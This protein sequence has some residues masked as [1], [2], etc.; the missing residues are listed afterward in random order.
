[1]TSD[2]D[3]AVGFLSY[4]HLDDEADG[5]RIRR[6]AQKIQAEYRVL[7]G[8]Q[9][10]IF[11]DRS[12]LR[13]GQ[14]WR[15]RIDG[16]LQSTTFFIPVLSPSFFASDE[17]RKEF[18]N[19]FNTTRSLGVPRY[20]LAIRYAP[21]DDLVEGSADQAKAIAAETQYKSWDTLRLEDENS[22]VHRAA[23][24]DLATELRTLM[25]EVQAQPAQAATAK[26]ASRE[27]VPD[28]SPE[29]GQSA[30]NSSSS[31]LDEE[32][33]YGDA[34]SPVDLVAELPER[35]SAWT[36]TMNEF[37]DAN[38][39]FNSRLTA[40]SADL[41]VANQGKNAFAAKIVILRRVADELERP[42]MVLEDI[43]ERYMRALLE[44]DPSFRAFA[45]IARNQVN[46]TDEDRRSL[47]EA[48]KSVRSMVSAGREAAASVRGAI[49]S[50]RGLARISRDLRPVLRR[51]ETAS[52][53]V[54]DGQAVLEEWT[55]LMDDVNWPEEPDEP[56]AR[57]S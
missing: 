4:S 19:F 26:G 44:L 56:A 52:Q 15:E 8:D 1:M 5:G 35:A 31:S 41:D 36:E 6:L 25:R 46:P 30:S 14:K 40:G 20:L 39:E 42:S 54:I 28:E 45:E 50:G 51:Y 57:Q 34:P 12:D 7:T 37:R 24:N 47:N 27:E 29:R 10:E 43:G 13:W 9:L 55:R 23:I 48:Q 32:D 38:Q 3:A 21:V 18:L 53:N 16:A 49:K 17:C 33:P 22:A 2:V 11:V